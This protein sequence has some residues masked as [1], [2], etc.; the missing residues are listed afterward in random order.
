MEALPVMLL[1]TDCVALGCD[2]GRCI[3]DLLDKLNCLGDQRG[4]IGVAVLVILCVD[5]CTNLE[6]AV[7]EVVVVGLEAK[8]LV[9]Q[10]LMSLIFLSAPSTP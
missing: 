9:K 6:E 5:Q 1:L 7:A 4:V 2:G 10:A 3:G 8:G